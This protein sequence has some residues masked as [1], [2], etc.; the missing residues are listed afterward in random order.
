MQRHQN[1]YPSKTVSFLPLHHRRRVPP[2][3]SATILLGAGAAITWRR[4]P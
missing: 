1:S 3:L 2:T 4:A